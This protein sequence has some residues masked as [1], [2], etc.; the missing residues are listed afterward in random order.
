MNVINRLRDGH[1]G[2]RGFTLIEMLFVLLITAIMMGIGIPTIHVQ[3]SRTKLRASGREVLDVLRSTR[4]SAVN[5][6]IPRYVQFTPPRTYRVFKYN[7]AAA[8]GAGAWEPDR[9]T[10]TLD[11]SVS[12]TAA[13]VTFP[14]LSDT[15]VAGMT[16]PEDAAY[17]GTRGRYPSTAAGGPYTIALVGGGGKT[18]TLTLYNT[19]GQAVGL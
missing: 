1:R 2:Q 3:I 11:P 16:V 12:F 19:T 18:I 6:G 5:E 14:T 17:F 15:P 9:G 13:G 8:G 10:T 4:D 7:P